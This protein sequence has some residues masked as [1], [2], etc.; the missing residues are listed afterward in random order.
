MNIPLNEMSVSEKLQAISLIWDSLLEDPDTIPAPDW[1]REE[2]EKRTQRLDSGE[3]AV[4]DWDEAE[5]RFD[6]LGS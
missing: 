6:Q 2:L 5:Q 4:S 3:T 1:Q